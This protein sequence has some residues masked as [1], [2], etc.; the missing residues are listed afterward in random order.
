MLDMYGACGVLL[1]VLQVI[2]SFDVRMD[3]ILVEFKNSC[4]RDASFLLLPK[5]SNVGFT[6]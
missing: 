3:V 1:L 2:F 4:L 5:H 6:K